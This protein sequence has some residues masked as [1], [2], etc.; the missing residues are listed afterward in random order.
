MTEPT[1]DFSSPILQEARHQPRWTFW[2][3]GAALLVIGI[4]GYG[5]ILQGRGQIAEGPAPDFTLETLEGQTIRL[6]DLRGTPVVLNFWS[7]W[8]IPCRTEMPLL[9]TT[10]RQY[11]TEVRFIG[12]A[13]VDTEQGARAF[14]DDY[15]VTYPNGLD[16][17]TRISDAYRI[18]GVPETFFIDRE[19]RIVGVKIGPLTEAE[20][21]G[22]LVELLK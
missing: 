4:L 13:Y 17:G 18:R 15:D 20:L 1:E 7:S 3:L 19:G 14:V 16:L 21:Q 12:V 2:A 6:S 11:E 22:W 10:S 9:E 5:I 8:C